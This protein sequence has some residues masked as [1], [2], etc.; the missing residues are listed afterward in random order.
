MLAILT[1][2]DVEKVVGVRVDEISDANLADLK[3]VAAERGTPLE[4][5]N[6]PAIGVDV[7]I[8]GVEMADDDPQGRSPSQ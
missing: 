4:D 3:L 7:Q 8:V 6:V 2:A 1:A 5:G